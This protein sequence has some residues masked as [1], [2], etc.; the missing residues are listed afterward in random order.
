MA[1]RDPKSGFYRL[2]KLDK[3]FWEII[4]GF[5]IIKKEM[6]KDCSKKEAGK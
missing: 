4:K 2:L 1:G 3:A 5:K 6:L